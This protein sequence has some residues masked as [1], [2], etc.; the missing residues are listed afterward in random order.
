MRKSFKEHYNT[1]LAG[2]ITN[3]TCKKL[4]IQYTKQ[5]RVCLGQHVYY[6]Y[7]RRLRSLRV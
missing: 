5:A 6:T 2:V 4:A 1:Y 3:L 7:F